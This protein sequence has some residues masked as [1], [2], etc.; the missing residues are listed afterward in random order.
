MDRLTAYQDQGRRNARDDE[1]GFDDRQSQDQQAPQPGRG[2]RRDPR[3]LVREAARAAPERQARRRRRRDVEEAAGD[4]N[5]HARAERRQA[6]RPGA[7]GAAGRPRG[8]RQ[9]GA[10]AQGG[11]AGAAPGAR[12]AGQGLEAQQEKL[13]TSEK[14]LSARIEAFRSQKEVIKAQYSAAEAQVRIGE[15]ATGIGEQ[16]ADTGL[17]IQRAKDKTEQMQ[18][19]ASAVDEL[20]ESG[21]LEDFTP[22]ARPISTASSGSSARAR[23]WTT[24]SRDEGRDRR[25]RQAEGDRAV[26]VRLHGR[27]AVPHRRLRPRRS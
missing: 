24:S 5:G 8:S 11:R 20:I 16:M 1:Q 2:S 27:G 13:V 6:G 19:R 23:R 10:A 21:A 7:P 3:L 26:I 22:A 9:G 4:A 15:A 25:R 14:Q 17:A 12:P 18:A